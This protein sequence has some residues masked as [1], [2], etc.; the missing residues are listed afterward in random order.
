MTPKAY[1]DGGAMFLPLARH[2]GAALAEFTPEEL[3]VATRLMNSMIEATIS[4]GRAAAAGEPVGA[5]QQ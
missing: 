5:E 3:E 2:M 4:A 1:S